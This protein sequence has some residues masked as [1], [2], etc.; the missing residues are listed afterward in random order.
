MKITLPD[1]TTGLIDDAQEKFEQLLIDHSLL[2]VGVLAAGDEISRSIN[3]DATSAATS[4]R[5]STTEYVFV[6]ILA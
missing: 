5:T 1:K 6:V 3:E 2:K 4:I